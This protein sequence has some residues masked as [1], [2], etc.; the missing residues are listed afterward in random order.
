M[1]LADMSVHGVPAVALPGGGG[2]DGS[3]GVDVAP[4]RRVASPQVA[5]RPPGGV[6]A[7][8][9]LLRPLSPNG[10]VWGSAELAGIEPGGCKV[11]ALLAMQ[12]ADMEHSVNSLRRGLDMRYH[13]ERSERI[14]IELMTSDRKLKASRQGSE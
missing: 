1:Q 9:G 11:D 3:A 13:S 8:R 6:A 12:L 2:G 7:A 14:F 5:A 4:A 10:A